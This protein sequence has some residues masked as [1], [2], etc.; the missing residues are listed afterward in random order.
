MKTE[1]EAGGTR[2]QAKEHLQPPEAGRGRKDPP[3][4]PLEGARPF[5]HFGFG[6]VIT[7]FGL[8][9][10][11]LDKVLLLEASCLWLF[12]PVAPGH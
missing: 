5:P 4:E 10:P 1:A 11:E 3:L 12:V 2:P 6:P 9:S 7:D 8:W